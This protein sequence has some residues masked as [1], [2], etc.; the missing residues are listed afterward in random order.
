ME[1]SASVFTDSPLLPSVMFPDVDRSWSRS[2]DPVDCVRLILFAILPYINA[3]G[4]M[5]LAP[6]SSFVP[7]HCLRRSRIGRLSPEW[8]SVDSSTLFFCD[9]GML[10]FPYEG[11]ARIELC[12]VAHLYKNRHLVSNMLKVI[13]I[14]LN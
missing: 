8:C 6:I 10:V 13:N 1:N 4:G 14:I 5:D 12:V 3:S 11:A 2:D 7:G 9:S